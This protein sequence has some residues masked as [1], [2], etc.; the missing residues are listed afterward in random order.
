VGCRGRG[1][2]S[3]MNARDLITVLEHAARRRRFCLFTALFSKIANKDRPNRILDVGGTWA[4]WRQMDWRALGDIEVV[5]LNVSLEKGLPY[6]FTSVV[7]DA[8]ELSGYAN[9][10]FDTVYSNSV[11]GHVGSFADQQRMAQEIRRVGRSYFVQTPNQNFVVDWRT[12]VPFFH[13]LPV[14]YQAWCLRHFRV[15]AYPRITDYSTSIHQAGRIRNVTFDELQSLFP[16]GAIVRE[17]VGGLTKSFMVH[18]GFL[19]SANNTVA[20]PTPTRWSVRR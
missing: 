8:R 3:H 10:E 2:T 9:Q 6:P 4:Y 14:P 19:N 13:F 15:G 18:S 12:L 17:R 5:L 7:C 20:L 1:S 11:L 16:N